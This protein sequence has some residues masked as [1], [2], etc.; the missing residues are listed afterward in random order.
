METTLNRL[1]P[2][3]RAKPATATAAPARQAGAPEF[4]PGRPSDRGPTRPTDTSE[5]QLDTA[6]E[7]EPSVIPAWGDLDYYQRRHADFE[8]RNPGME[9]PDYYLAY[10]DKYIQRFNDEV[11]PELSPEGQAWLDRTRVN[12]QKAIEDK[13][14]E[15]PQAFAELERNP[16]AFRKFAYDSHVKA[17]LDAGLA[18][19]P[20]E[21]LVRIGLTPDMSDLFNQ[22]G[23]EQ[24]VRVADD[25]L[26]SKLEDTVGLDEETGRQVLDLMGEGLAKGEAAAEDVAR[27][28]DTA[29][30]PLQLLE[31]YAGLVGHALE[32]PGELA[33]K[34][35]RK[36]VDV[37]EG[38]GGK[39]KDAFNRVFR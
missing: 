22:A 2:S 32:L 12:L 29:T 28:I 30:S 8:R 5:L 15:D 1:M 6:T 37:A 33:Q 31:D 21:D 35:G 13:R 9:P 34:V 3:W 24:A 26:L 39:L 17:Y 38:V 11:R 19:L 18:D 20:V 14:F 16:D 36:V 25:V 7:P 10:G 23:L 4:R 27:L